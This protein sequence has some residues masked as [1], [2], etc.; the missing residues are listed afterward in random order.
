MFLRVLRGAADYRA[1]ER[2]QA[3]LFRIARNV[4]LDDR[5]RDSAAPALVAIA[6]ERLT[7]PA[8]AVSAGLREALGNLPREDREALLLGEVGGSRIAKSRPR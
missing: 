5:R 2:E 7:P 6:A 1:V 8:Q 4:F 3:W